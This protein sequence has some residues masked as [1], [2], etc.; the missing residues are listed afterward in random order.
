MPIYPIFASFIYDS[1]VIDFYRWDIDESSILESY[2]DGE[3]EALYISDDEFLSVN[4]LFD[5]KRDMSWVNEVIDYEVKQWD[6]YSSIGY[7]FWITKNSILWANNFTVNHM[8]HPWDK[9]KVPSVSWVI[10][11][12]KDWETIDMIA[13]K[14]SVKKDTIVTQNSLSW[15]TSIDKWLVLIIPG[16]V[17]KSSWWVRIK[18]P[19]KSYTKNVPGKKYYTKWSGSSEY[20][21][22]DGVYELVA[23]KPK[24]KFYWGNCTYFV[25]KFKDVIWWG[26][27][28][29]WLSNAK[30]AWVP[31]WNKP[32]VW[33][34]IVFNGRWYNPWYGHVGIVI[35][36]EKD[37]VIVKDMNYRK[38]NEVTVRRVP[39]SD[40]AIRWY[41]YTD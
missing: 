26:N 7:K 39:K 33:A 1:A 31:T 5:G 37:Y 11:T 9:I 32:W 40:R 15:I 19:P 3:N 8:L 12:V 16:A 2:Q 30:K 6:S 28:K 14:Y 35:D 41:I 23:R 22:T 36:V 29:Q 10:H 20:V 24:R 17:K 4:T 18:N 34:I 38:I 25:A 21:E 27:A 13:K